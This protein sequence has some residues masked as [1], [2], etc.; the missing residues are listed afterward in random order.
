MLMQ[1]VR[2]RDK[3][4]GSFRNEQNWVG[5]KGCAINNAAFVPIPQEHLMTGLERWSTYAQST[6]EPDPLVQLALI[7]VEFEALHPFKDGNGRLGRIIIPLFLYWRRLLQGPNFYMSSYLEARRD[8]YVETMRNVS[9]DAAWTEWVIFFLQGIIEQSSENQNKASAILDLHRRMLT[10]IPKLT[11]S[12]FSP[13]V[14]EFLFSRPIFSSAHFLKAA[15]IPKPSA[16]RILATLREARILRTLREASGRRP[17]FY[18][19]YD[20][21]NVAEGKDSV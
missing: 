1:G 19:F 17:A 7:H 15:K 3:S 12:R 5:L 18:A 4:P 20:L 8:E 21:V 2:G 6:E 13:Y 16:M 14:V 10:D 9:R 11:H